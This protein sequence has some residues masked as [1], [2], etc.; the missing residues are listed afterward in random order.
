MS[1]AS[2]I[3]DLSTNLTAAKDAVVAK[4]GTVG[5]TGLAGLSTEI[6]TIPMPVTYDYGTV[7][8]GATTVAGSVE[9]SSNCTVTI[10]DA[11]GV[12]DYLLRN[13]LVYDNS[14]VSQDLLEYSFSASYSDEGWRESGNYNTFSLAALEAA[15]MS[16]TL[17][18]GATSANFTIAFDF[19]VSSA[20]TT[21]TQITDK[22][23]Y[24]TLGYIALT[25]DRSGGYG[26]GP[27]L[28][29]FTID[30]DYYPRVS[31]I[32]YE[33]GVDSGRT[34]NYFLSGCRCLTSVDLTGVTEIGDCFMNNCESFNATLTIPSTV[35]SIGSYFL[36]YCS[37]FNQPITI[38]A[39]VTSIGDYALSELSVFNSAVSILA[40]VRELRY[41]MHYA[42][43]F[44]QPITIPSTVEDI[45][46]FMEASQVF[47]Q[48]VTI[49]SG[50]K[51]AG[52]FLAEAK[53]FNQPVTIPE[54]V[55]NLNNFLQ[56]TSVFNQPITIPSTVE[57]CTY[58]LTRNTVFNS[59]VTIASGAK[60]IT[61]YFL[62]SCSAFNKPI[63][64]PSSVESIGQGFLSSCSSFNS[65]VT[66]PGVKTIDTN[67]L[68]NCSS[69]N[70]DI[71]IPATLTS[72]RSSFLWACTN[73]VH[74]VYVN[75][76]YTPAR[77]NYS[78]STNQNS[79]PMYT[80]GVKVGGTY[81]SNWRTAWPNR[82]S[83]PYR[84]LIAA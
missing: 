42:Y 32:G 76:S 75:T 10:T 8:L 40:P 60:K 17:A 54:G 38:P 71:T 44:N 67:F 26:Q 83:S 25:Y 27:S 69:F 82:T 23:D 55:T 30:G 15:G 39:T 79:A 68:S 66:M 2:E 7:I 84:K 46:G 62:T 78:L 53:A 52:M 22:F 64:L 59:T 47:N 63:S 29:W 34:P 20:N 1:I 74:T 9:S 58:F 21:R 33:A 4:G 41:F 24:Y 12:L 72:I 36:S 13:G 43:A 31:V 37:S 73:M 28:T 45:H 18:T 49:P 11:D 16:V 81:G 77:D 35:T 56:N 3:T 57:N 50:V 5:D 70:Q 80:T 61:N 14:D 19:T 6:A 48:Q 51:D 65:T